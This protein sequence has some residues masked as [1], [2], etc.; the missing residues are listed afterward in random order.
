MFR[1]RVLLAS[2][3]ASLSLVSPS[4]AEESARPGDTVG[5]AVAA[6]D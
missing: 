4:L 5:F 1:S 2:L 3:F 6:E